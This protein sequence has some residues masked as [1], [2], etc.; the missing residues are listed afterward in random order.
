MTMWRPPQLAANLRTAL[1][2]SALAVLLIA[3]GRCSEP[4]PAPEIPL[5]TN[6][7]D[8]AAPSTAVANARAIEAGVIASTARVQPATVCLVFEDEAKNRRGTGSGVIV[9]D[10]GSRAVVLTCGHVTRE[11]GRSCSVVL[12][13]GRLF[14]GAST[15]SLQRE[16]IDLGLVAFETNGERVPV[17][18]LAVARPSMG[19]WVVVL[20]HPRG[21]WIEDAE[22]DSAISPTETDP[23]AMPSITGTSGAPR[24]RTDSGA[25][26]RAHDRSTLSQAVRP[27]VV[28]AGRLW[29]EPGAEI[30]LRFDAPI[31]AGDS[32]GPVVDLSGRIVGVAS[33]CGWK[34]FWNWASSTE[35]L[36]GDP[37]RLLDPTLSVPEGSADPGAGAG[38]ARIPDESRDALPR[39]ASLRAVAQR[40]GSSVIAVEAEGGVRA[41]AIAVARGGYFATKG[42]EVGFAAPLVGVHGGRRIPATRIA[43]DPDADV[44]LIRAEALDLPLPPTIS[45]TEPAPGTLLLNIGADGE[46][47]SKGVM[48]LVSSRIEEPDARPFLGVSWRADRDGAARVASVVPGTPAARAGVLVGDRILSADDRPIATRRSLSEWIA[49]KQV[50]DALALVIDRKGERRTLVVHLD[51]RQPSIRVRDRGNTRSSVSRVLPFRTLVWQQDGVVDPDQCGSAVIDLEG[52]MVGMN[53]GR[54]DRTATLVMPAEELHRRARL[55]MARS[56]PDLQ[57]LDA[58]ASA[59]FAATEAAGVI[60]LSTLDARFVGPRR[61]ARLVGNALTPDGSGT[62]IMSDDRLL[63][64][65][66][67]DAPGR[68]EVVLTGRV[69]AP[70]QV[71]LEVGERGFEAEVPEGRHRQGTVLGEIEIDHVGRLPIA[72]EWLGGGG[73]EIPGSITSIELRRVSGTSNT[74]IGRGG[75]HSPHRLSDRTPTTQWSRGISH[76]IL[77][78]ARATHPHRR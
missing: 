12:P 45:A 77:C 61:M 76:G 1:S 31:E 38:N 42:S 27:P 41:F 9:A 20:G 36:Q 29:A 50:G 78:F 24:W 33:R 23:A 37:M 6:S 15:A 47:F 34:S 60:R 22:E 62:T 68:F 17:A 75:L 70:R 72:F 69:R 2:V 40:T 67:I 44:L 59:S 8:A 10:D 25:P 7:V 65:A 74:T 51:R 63:W 43:Y 55:L 46:I 39:L 26:S 73:D 11:A 28:R 13:D 48:S 32:G 52:R 30:G 64:D 54:A 71:R 5:G 4:R 49:T 58:L 57:R 21:L 19:D 66:M 18:E 14:T 53:V 16:G 3:L 56:E 35:L